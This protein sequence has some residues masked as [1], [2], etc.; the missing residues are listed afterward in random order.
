MAVSLRY[1]AECRVILM[2][3]PRMDDHQILEM[4]GIATRLVKYL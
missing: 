4:V 3:T 2:R 1:T